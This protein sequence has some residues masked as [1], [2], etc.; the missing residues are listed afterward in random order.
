MIFYDKLVQHCCWCGR[1]DSVRQG[2]GGAQHPLS[3]FQAPVLMPH[4]STPIQHPHY[5]HAVAACNCMAVMF[6]V[7]CQPTNDPIQKRG[8][9]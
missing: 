8:N 6:P 5:S 9:Y 7:K 3:V 2:L 1:R 4:L